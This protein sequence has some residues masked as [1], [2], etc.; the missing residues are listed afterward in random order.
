MVSN[1]FLFFQI[2][3]SLLMPRLLATH[4]VIKLEKT[5]ENAKKETY[6]HYSTTM[7][8]YLSRKT[9]LGMA[10]LHTHRKV[11]KIFLII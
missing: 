3:F 8:F 11:E 1:N 4:I 2:P 6:I 7:V 5:G 10:F 9:K